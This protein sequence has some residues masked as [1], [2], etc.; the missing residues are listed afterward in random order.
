M[1]KWFVSLLFLASMLCS[2]IAL[3]LTSTPAKAYAGPN[4]EVFYACCYAFN[5]P[6]TVAPICITSP[7]ST[8]SLP[9]PVCNGWLGFCDPEG[10]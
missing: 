4:R 5:G 8:C 2:L 9:A 7:I 10:Q 3:S 1:K 6:V